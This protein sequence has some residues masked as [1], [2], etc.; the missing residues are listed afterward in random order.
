MTGPVASAEGSRG[1]TVAS[2]VSAGVAGTV[3]SFA[4]DWA[5]VGRTMSGCSTTAGRW[6]SFS[7]AGLIITDM[8]AGR[9]CDPD[10]EDARM[11]GG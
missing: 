1:R 11:R 7:K 3:R 8:F 9:V 10:A 5:N 6:L 4:P 2:R